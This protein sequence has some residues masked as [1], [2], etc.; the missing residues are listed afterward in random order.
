MDAAVLDANVVLRY[1]LGDHAELTQKAEEIIAPIRSGD[2]LALVP[3]AV[4]AE[5]VFVLFRQYRV[6]RGE[7]RELL[8]KFLGS[9]GLIGDHLPLMRNALELFAGSTLSF[10]DALVYLTAKQNNFD[11]VTFDEDLK[12]LASRQPE[13]Q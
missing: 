2:S 13:S 3:E 6:P 4:I 10:V 9:R 1:L 12:K 11:L 7:I 8:A 5:C